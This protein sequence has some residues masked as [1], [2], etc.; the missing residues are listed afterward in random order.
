[1]F[2]KSVKS[3]KIVPLLCAVLCAAA[4]LHAEE[5]SA[6]WFWNK[7]IADISFEGL[8][9]VKKSELT[10]V[11]N[12]FIGKNFTQEVYDQILDRLYGL[13]YFEDINP[14][15]KHN[16]R[17]PEKINLVFQ[18]TEY[19]SISSIEFKGNKKIRTT[20]L[21]DTLTAKVGDVFVDSA[22][23]LDERAVRDLYIKKGFMEAEISH[24]TTQ[25]PDG[26]KITFTI[27]EG[28]ATVIAK[29]L[30]S[31]NTLFSQRTL[32][33]KLKLKEAGFVKDGAFQLSTLEADK[34]T[35]VAYY[36]TRGYADARVLDVVQET[37]FNEKKKRTELTLTFVLQ[38]GAQYTFGGLSISGNEIFSTEKLMSFIKLN[39]GDVFNQTKFHEG[40]SGIT[41]LYYENGYMTNDFQPEIEKDVERRSIAYTL[42]ITERSRAHIE[43]IIVK[44]NTKTKDYVIMREI[45]LEPGDVFSREKILTGV[46][47][48]YNT[49]YFSNVIPEPVSGSEE[50]L[51]DLV[52]TVEEQ[53][54]TSLQ[55][56][57]SFSGVQK[58]DDFPIAL[59]AKVENSNF[60]GLGKSLG[61]GTNISSNEQSVDFTFGQAWMFNKPI[62]WSES[63][64]FFHSN[65]STL[66]LNW[67]ANGRLDDDYY[68]MQFESWGASLNS[69]LGRRWL[70]SFA[71]FTLSGGLTNTMTDNIYRE[72]LY[73]P[74]DSGVN[75]NA[76]RF[77]LKNAVYISASL[78][79]R[80]VNYDPSTGWFVNQRFTWYGLLP[81]IE[82]EFYLRSDT[83]LE[84]YL[85]LF[86]IPL[87]NGYWNFK[88]V[89]AGYTGLTT[90]F[91]V[92]GTL[93]GDSSK[94]YIDGMF[95][96]RGWTNVYNRAR[97]K[98]M[99]SNKV[100]LR[101]PIFPGVIGI[102][103]FFDAA[104]V[105]N[106]PEQIFRDLSANDFYFSFGPAI[107]FL[108]PQFPL[109]L[110]FAN[111]FR[112][113]DGKTEW[114]DTWKFVLSFNIVNR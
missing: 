69:A 28:G 20:E 27:K 68:Y 106:E 84:G 36:T 48:L 24:Q 74:V 8:K 55:F 34:Q 96:G 73:T 26:I 112:I 49:Q 80:D 14:Y 4:V 101:M 41:N 35:I 63:L 105:K 110:L 7:P 45:P 13:S 78:D 93:F 31:G 89:L 9:S 107:R 91:P 85:K 109:H 29:I 90:I 66:A 71:I 60:R 18:V 62:S 52:I 88:M 40:L 83:K 15:A 1:M 87:F 81:R 30:F 82:Q 100:E 3:N 19:P 58:A 102:A 67:L 50:N 59:F 95:N 86:D 32:K 113:Q 72:T 51:V 33:S 22:V 64:S 42:K 53:S 65:S 2:L 57:M 70:P 12:G 99:L 47:N 54:T 6:D 11:T 98:A 39:Q 25:T 21:R 111:N 79:D 104:A 94:A 43:N 103:G 108:I 44:G 17:N 23:L 10:G 75:K 114:G 5:E 92:P 97:G 16:K 37:S 46:R 61:V 38:E 56:G 76:N 77:G